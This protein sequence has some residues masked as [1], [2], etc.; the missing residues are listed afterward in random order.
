MYNAL[1]DNWSRRRVQSGAIWDICPK[2]LPKFSSM[3]EVAHDFVDVSIENLQ[4]IVAAELKRIHAQR[5]EILV[6][7][8]AKYQ[9]EP[10]DCVQV[11]TQ[12]TGGTRKYF[13]RQ[14]TLEERE[15]I[16]RMSSEL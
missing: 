8:M 5:E 11:E 16:S 12:M 7:F 4:E 3:P 6:A 2:C 15:M 9:C 14:R 1:E 13:V 10:D